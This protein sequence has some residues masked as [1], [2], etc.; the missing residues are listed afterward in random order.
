MKGPTFCAAALVCGG[1]VALRALIGGVAALPDVCLN[2]SRLR[3]SVDRGGAVEPSGCGV[4]IT[5]V[6]GL[7]CERCMS[8]VVK[9]YATATQLTST[10]EAW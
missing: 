8:Q 10:F 7:C 3:R 2:L 5:D 4:F 6:L 1:E 9:L